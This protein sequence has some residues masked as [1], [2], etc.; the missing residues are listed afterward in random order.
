MESQ[1]RDCVQTPSNSVGGNHLSPPLRLNKF[2]TVRHQHHLIRVHELVPKAVMSAFLECAA[3]R[4]P[5]PLTICS[6]QGRGKTRSTLLFLDR[7]N[8]ETLF[9]TL[10]QMCEALTDAMNDAYEPGGFRVRPTQFWE[11]WG[12]A[13]CCA[14][15]EIG[16][17]TAVSDFRYETMIRALNEREGM[18]LIIT[19][20]IDEVGIAKLY[21]GRVASRICGGTFVLVPESMPDLRMTPIGRVQLHPE[22]I[23]H[24]QLN[25]RESIRQK[26]FEKQAQDWA[27]E[28][29]FNKLK[30]LFDSIPEG[31]RRQRYLFNPL[32]CE[33]FLFGRFAPNKFV[34]PALPEI[35]TSI[36]LS[37]QR[38][39]CAERP[40]NHKRRYLTHHNLTEVK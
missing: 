7:V 19:T 21:D 5:F 12:S 3:G 22:D 26:A 9:F 8:G 18:P 29:G 13:A 23:T 37:S 16:S 14:L 20:N 28:I 40:L 1:L 35:P 25:E 2:R 15:D 30:E 17:R 39:Q 4:S 31:E 34:E 6:P 11:Q 10:E 36:D 38:L 27:S 32:R 24:A 33:A